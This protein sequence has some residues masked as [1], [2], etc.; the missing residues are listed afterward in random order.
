M[1]KLYQM[2]ISHFCEKIRWTL[3]YKNLRYKPVNLLPGLHAR[4]TKR[5]TGQTSVP[6]LK[7]G[8]KIV[9]NSSTIIT[10][11]DETYPSGPLTP[12][13][14]E[15]RQEAMDWEAY[16]DANIGMQMRLICYDILL[17]HPDVL[18]PIFTQ[19]GPWYGPPIMKW[20]YPKV[21]HVIRKLLHIN[22]ATV[23]EARLR[24]NG[25]LESISAHLEGRQFM[26]GNSFSRADLAASALL[27]PLIMPAQY[28]VH[29]P[30]GYAEVMKPTM[31]EY[32]GKMDWAV[33][34]YQRFR[35]H[36]GHPQ[37]AR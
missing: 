31:D 16:A 27:A 18:L 19:G 25:A 26:V 9:H 32:R 4:T 14:T 7:D 37:C 5:L 28:G 8:S 13:D 22:P 10:Y 29:W 11:L 34:N 30:A 33:N 17:E 1:L 36:P 21:R 6:V 12:V 24:M 15:A 23:A 2:P 3:D 20:Q 35:G